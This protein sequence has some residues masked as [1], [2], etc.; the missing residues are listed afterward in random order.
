MTMSTELVSVNSDEQTETGI[1]NVRTLLFCRVSKN[2]LEREFWEKDKWVLDKGNRELEKDDPRSPY[3]R[4]HKKLYEKI[5]ELE[6]NVQDKKCFFALG[7][8]D[9]LCVYKTPIENPCSGQ[10]FKKIYEDKQRIIREISPDLLLHQMHLVKSSDDSDFW[11]ASDQ[12]YP[13]FLVTCIYGVKHTDDWK[14]DPSYCSQYEQNIDEHLKQKVS[15]RSILYSVYNGI[16]ISDVVVLWKAK[17]LAEV[18]KIIPLIVLDGKARKTLTTISF[19]M[20]RGEIKKDALAALKAMGE[21]YDLSLSV[22]GAIRSASGFQPVRKHLQEI[23]RVAKGY[24]NFGVNDFTIEADVSGEIVANLLELY[25]SDHDAIS[26]CC[27]EIHTDL[28]TKYVDPQGYDDAPAFPSSIL[29]KEYEKFLQNCKQHQLDMYPWCRSLRELLATN[30]NIDRNPVL[31]G[32]SY[33][34]YYTIRIINAYLSNSV[35]DFASAERMKA[36]LL[37][38]EI[39]LLRF[40]RSWD[41][42]TEQIIRNDD[43]ILGGRNNSH[44]IHVSLPE[45][46]LDFYHAFLRRSVELLMECDREKRGKSRIPENFAFDL[47]L[48]PDNSPRFQVSQL[49]VTDTDKKPPKQDSQNNT[50]WPQQQAYLLELPMDSVF[51][52]MDMIIP[53]IHE[54]CHGFGDTLRKRRKRRMYMSA[55]IATV[56]ISNLELGNRNQRDFHKT[57]TKLICGEKPDDYSAYYLKRTCDD[58]RKNLVSLMGADGSK[59]LLDQHPTAYFLFADAVLYKSKRMADRCSVDSTDRRIPFTQHIVA[60]ARYYFKECYADA[61]TIALLDLKPSEYL[62]RFRTEV[63]RYDFDNNQGREEEE[64]KRHICNGQVDMAW[65]AQRIAIVL[66]ACGSKAMEGKLTYFSEEECSKAVERIALWPDQKVGEYKKTYKLLGKMIQLILKTLIQE[67]QRL[68]LEDKESELYSKLSM[69]GDEPNFLDACCPP[70]ALKYVQD[71][72]EEAITNL[73]EIS[74]KLEMGHDTTKNAYS[75][76]ASIGSDAH[77]LS[78]DFHEIIREGRMF[79]SR[80]YQL[81]QEYHS[82][83]RSKV[84]NDSWPNV[85]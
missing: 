14:L 46:A 47:L 36:L 73:F 4:T 80:F 85:K 65:L 49:F 24:Q 78:G 23:L 68:E 59:K 11:Q 82:D 79:G 75:L 50:V 70:A 29:Y 8:F 1:P 16:S 40:V 44:T 74:P 39:N 25:T 3:L 26:N 61:M 42:L 28:K 43:V 21:E 37:A 22:R 15:N 45:S 9:A 72:L 69:D 55:F 18:L 52:P 51:S 83:I 77:S 7:S 84:Q 13:F 81:I 6:L 2:Y 57:V 10:W 35:A 38:S 20:E 76:H 33:L 67:N 66:A 12:E 56:F 19:P 54:C 17:N 27:W 32:P 30:S 71:Y 63:S 58:L 53:V 60:H 48:I 41:Q 5:E 31:H 62:E 64:Q 34:V